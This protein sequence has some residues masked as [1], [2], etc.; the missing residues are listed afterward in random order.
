MRGGASWITEAGAV[1]YAHV[2]DGDA[3]EDL[4]GLAEVIAHRIKVRDGM[5]VCPVCGQLM[6]PESGRFKRVTHEHDGFTISR[7]LR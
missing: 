3:D 2:V 4:E 1:V 7:S 6:E 5:P